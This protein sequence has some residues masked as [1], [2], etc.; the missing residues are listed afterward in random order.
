MSDDEL[1]KLSKLTKFTKYLLEIETDIWLAFKT[2]AIANNLKVKDAIRQAILE[3]IQN[4]QLP[5]QKV[6]VKIIENKEAK[7]NILQ[8]VIEE[9]I[10]TTLKELLDAKA[11]KA[12]ISYI[13]ELKKYL[14][15]Q[16]KKAPLVSKDLANEIKFVLQNLRT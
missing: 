14:I 15:E 12:N 6:E 4:H 10:R 2:I 7:E 11:R 5:N 3:Y 1:S 9:D 8:I 13:N 16:V